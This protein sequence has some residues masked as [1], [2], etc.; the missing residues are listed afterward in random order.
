MALLQGG[1]PELALHA[2]GIAD[3]AVFMLQSALALGAALATVLAAAVAGARQAVRAAIVFVAAA[4]ASAWL[5]AT[6]PAAS[7]VP[8]VLLVLGIVL[9][10][11][12]RLRGA[13]AWIAIVVGGTT[14]GLAGGLPTAT[15][16]ESGGGLLVLALLVLA[17]FVLAVRVVVPPRVERGVATARRMAGAWISAVGVLLIALWLRRGG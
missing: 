11:G 5:P 8:G 3:G 6:V 16:E 15:W 13:P 17:G 4:A 1:V 14:A 2:R 10:A 7:L 12:L 9:A